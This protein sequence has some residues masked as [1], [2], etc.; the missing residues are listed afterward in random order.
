SEEQA[1]RS[2]MRF[3]EFQDQNGRFSQQIF[4]RQVRNMGYTPTSFLGVLRN[5]MLMNQ[6]RAGYEE[7]DFGLPYELADLR[8]LGEQRRDI[9]YIRVSAE[10]LLSDFDISDE[11]V[12]AFYEDN[13]REFVR[14]PEFSLHYIEL[15]RAAYLDDIQVTEEQARAEY[16]AREEMFKTVAAQQE[17]RRVSHILIAEKDGVSE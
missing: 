17:R 9:S 8:R 10:S 11:Q 6:I 4:D 16:Q 7:T 15:D 14:P 3:G 12:Q 5:D 13:E 1:A 2:L